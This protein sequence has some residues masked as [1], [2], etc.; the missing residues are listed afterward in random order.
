VLCPNVPSR[1]LDALRALLHLAM[2]SYTTQAKGSNAHHAS[3]WEGCD[4]RPK[5]SSLASGGGTENAQAT[6]LGLPKA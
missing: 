3:K 6:E 5:R 2:D 4:M 1:Q